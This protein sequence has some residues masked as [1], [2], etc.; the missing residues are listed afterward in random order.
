MLMVWRRTPKT[1]TEQKVPRAEE[2]DFSSFSSPAVAMLTTPA[3]PHFSDMNVRR[4]VSVLSFFA[5]VEGL[6]ASDVK[7][8]G[9][10]GRY[11]L[12]RDGN[13]EEDVHGTERA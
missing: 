4:Y 6:T 11:V 10:I 7:A 13:K 12:H 3:S 1:Q 9:M 2:P 8:V 5:P